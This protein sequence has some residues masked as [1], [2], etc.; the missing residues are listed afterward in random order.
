M[1]EPAPLP[2]PPHSPPRLPSTLSSF[3][4]PSP[5]LSSSPSSPLPASEPPTSP[6]PTADQ[7]VFR[8]DRPH[9]L[10]SSYLAARESLTQSHVDALSAE[11][12]AVLPPPPV[13]E[14][15]AANGGE[16]SSAKGGS[17]AG[18]AT[19]DPNPEE[20]ARQRR[21]SMILS[22]LGMILGSVSLSLSTGTLLAQ[23]EEPS[24]PSSPSHDARA[25]EADHLRQDDPSPA[26]QRTYVSA[27][28]SASGIGMDFGTF[29]GFGGFG[30]TSR[31]PFGREDSGSTGEEMYE[32]ADEGDDDPLAWMSRRSSRSNGGGGAPHPRSRKNSLAQ[33]P[34][35]LST[36][37]DTSPLVPDSATIPTTSPQF[38]LE[39][40]EV[41]FGYACG[42]PS[43]PL[44]VEAD[45]EAEEVDDGAE[46]DE[47]GEQE[48]D[49]DDDRASMT[50]VGQLVR[51]SWRLSRPGNGNGAT[52][53]RRTSSRNA[54]L[55]SATAAEGDDGL[56]INLA[57][58]DF[59]T[60][61]PSAT[62]RP[63]AS[64]Q[65]SYQS[66]YQPSSRPLHA[67]PS[68]ADAFPEVSTSP[69]SST[70]AS[71]LAGR[72]PTSPPLV[73]GSLT[74]GSAAA[75]PSLSNTPSPSSIASAQRTPSFL[76]SDPG[77]EHPLSAS[78]GSARAPPP[79]SPQPPRSSSLAAS[80][81]NLPSN[82]PPQLHHQSSNESKLNRR[83][84]TL[85]SSKSS[86][87]L[88]ALLT[89][90]F[91][92]VRSRTSSYNSAD[93]DDKDSKDD[94][95]SG[96]RRSK[97]DGPISG[98]ISAPLPSAPF[99][100]DPPIRRAA[101]PE[102]LSASSFSAP[103]SSGA[104]SLGAPTPSLTQSPMAGRT[105]RSTLS[106]DE[107]EQ[108]V[109]SFGALEM[110]RQEVIWE[111]CETERS[112]VNGLRGVIQVFTLPLRTRS[113]AWIKG[114]PVPVSRLLDWLDDI[115]YLHSQISAA[116]DLAREKQYPVV[117]KLAEAFLPFVQRLEVHQPYLVRFEAVTR[118]IDEM[119]ADQESDFGEFVR[120]Q[121][122]L[123]ECGSLSLSSFLLKPVQR[124]MKYPLFFRQLCD[125]TPTNH[126]DH[127]SILNLLHSTDSTIR[128]LQ[129]VKTREDEYE[130]AKVLQSRIRGLPEG[131]HLATRDRRLVAHGVLRRVHVNDRD[132]G[133][134]EMD[135]MARAGRRG[136]ALRGGAP[137][138]PS[139]SIPPRQLGQSQVDGSRP[140]S[141]IS[142]SGSSS[143]TDRSTSSLGW[144]PPTTPG[145]ALPTSPG[146]P[147]LRLDSMV[148]NSSS[149][150]SDDYAA[151]AAAAAAA[152]GSIPLSAFSSA[153]TR[154][155][156]AQQQ[157]LV[158]TK[159]KE[160]SVHV[161][162][163][164]DLIVLATKH[165]DAGK[166]I[167][168]AAA[169]AKGG[170][171]SGE[172]EREGAVPTYRALEGVG[173]ARVLGVSD[174]SGKTEHD[175][176]IEVD[177]LPIVTG[178]DHFTPLSLSN[179]SLATSIYFT[180]P[181]ASSARSPASPVSPTL[182]P[183]PSQSLF[184]E[185]LRWLQ[186][187]ERSYLFALRSLSFPSSS[188]STNSTSH[189]SSAA[190][191]NAFT[192]PITHS[193]RL[194]VASYI[195][196]GIIP[197]SPSEQA[198]EKLDRQQRRRARERSASVS[199]SNGGGGGG[200]SGTDVDEP[201][202]AQL[203]REERGWWAVRLKTVRKEL[204]GSAMHHHPAAHPFNSST[205]ASSASAGAGGAPGASWHPASNGGR[206]MGRKS[207]GGGTVRV[208]RVSGGGGGG[209]G[210]N[211]GLGIESL[212]RGMGR[213]ASG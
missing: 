67:R 165:S 134:L 48:E 162:V 37:I 110:R 34:S 174:L 35:T 8:L 144:T 13:G 197:K 175:H 66:S 61:T 146:F 41:A 62:V 49:D 46:A 178:Q 136:A 191:L 147:H 103:P 98:P 4:F 179:T 56:G 166:F 1:I 138:P 21:L 207:A 135:A 60:S 79:R 38:R 118:S 112:F 211:P 199:S 5:T 20:W 15:D 92:I 59:G 126:P 111:L 212:G 198:L 169:A 23:D 128:C 94:L 109:L 93:G 196:A 26:S 210:G 155:Q 70:S 119:T 170:R 30:E 42:S 115:V 185:R 209:G 83:R 28:S 129:E 143:L 14:S 183:D 120:M 200:A 40:P 74:P 88:S 85:S 9:A 71:F 27:S 36:I 69:V 194:S 43:P 161:F 84:S 16:G 106:D 107:Y 76:D 172:K 123:P 201:D 64:Q 184:A 78:T 173:V 97:T 152:N 187:F 22:G 95:R 131:F 167:R 82:P 127:F 58:L 149:T 89:S 151:S 57:A 122:S 193:E 80:T 19:L 142:D 180:L 163:F 104:P 139:L 75:T 91:D 47:D 202:P 25:I 31:P 101:T 96:R 195:S 168:N 171:K 205:S 160:S 206:T 158:K 63:R 53:P 145:S 116:L 33:L 157:R 90:G 186:A 102:P 189:S 54:V 130:E 10:P 117:L 150:Y 45:E 68:I 39:S 50:S 192:A 140:E 156:T 124:L 213:R 177:L 32:S 2:S 190:A 164:S 108:L 176:L 204:E 125:L 51:Q 153:S 113:G 52:L 29:G 73:S 3:V 65:R 121:S 55:G 208:P 6:P 18:E 72:L 188:S 159:A 99:P 137:L 7:S 86:K 154:S 114:V 11:L 77:A 24:S 105:W 132:R 17:A 12:A 100:P 148:S 181:S 141:T 81:A 133:V 87:R 182:S 203:E 44:I